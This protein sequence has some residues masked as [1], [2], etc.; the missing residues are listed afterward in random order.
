MLRYYGTSLFT[1]KA[2]LVIVL[3]VAALSALHAETRIF[4]DTSGRT[5]KAE[6]S[7]I[8]G[9]NVILKRE[10]GQV[11]KIKASTFSPPDIA[12]F[13]EHGLRDSPAAPVA[14][15]APNKPDTL[16]GNAVIIEAFIDGPSELRVRKD[17]IYWINFDNAKPGKHDNEHYP[18]YV[19]GKPWQPG[20]K[21]PRKSRG[22]DRTA[23]HGVVFGV[24]PEKL[25]FKLLAVTLSRD[26]TG[27]EKR[28]EIKVTVAD[29]ELSI[30][31]PDSQSG[32]RWYKFALYPKQQ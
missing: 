1:M 9:D 2:L 31:I 28:D 8:D 10:D 20:W 26:L 19:N 18:T 4:T 16:P 13:K 3:F 30:L 29:K 5:T 23:V 25:D 6:L 12:Y 7:G 32:S 11:F 17:G 24:N 21:E 27:I 14:V 22:A 15:A